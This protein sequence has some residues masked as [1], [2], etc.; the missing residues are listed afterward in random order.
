MTVYLYFYFTVF[1]M[2]HPQLLMYSADQNITLWQLKKQSSQ[3]IDTTQIQTWME[4]NHVQWC[5]EWTPEFHYKFWFP[6][7][8]PHL[9]YYMGNIDLLDK[10]ILA[11]VGPRKHTSY[12]QQ[13]LENIFNQLQHYQVATISGMAPWVDQLCHKYSLDHNI[14]TIAVL[15]WGLRYFLESKDRHRIESIVQKWWLVISEYKLDQQPTTYTFPQRNRIIAW[16]ADVV[17]LPE[18]SKNSWSLITVDFAAQMKKSIYW[19]PNTIFSE[20]SQ[21]LHEYLA[22]GIVQMIDDIPSWLDRYF[23]KSWST[24]VPSL[25]HLSADEKSLITLIKNQAMISFDEIQNKLQK[26]SQEIMTTLTLLELQNLTY[27]TTPGIYKLR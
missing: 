16:L 25:S 10:P 14:P 3:N 12:A 15:G 27:Q 17:F 2:L 11:I 9:M 4:Q 19:V 24:K 1:P 7:A 8:K 22:K 18:A 6:K 5:V 20:S 23:A 26:S 21:G 13:V